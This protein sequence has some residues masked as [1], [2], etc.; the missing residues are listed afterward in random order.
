MLIISA[1]FVALFLSGG[2]MWMFLPY[3][4]CGFVFFFVG[5]TEDSR[6][7]LLVGW[8]F[9]AAMT[10]ALAAARKPAI[11]WPLFVLLLLAFGLNVHGCHRM[12]KW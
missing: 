8:L 4:P 10:T 5:S 1:W 9:Y 12:I 11:F 3:F 6:S 2:F 7:C